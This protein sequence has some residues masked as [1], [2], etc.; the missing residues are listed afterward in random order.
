M[1]NGAEKHPCVQ[2][3][4]QARRGMARCRRCQ[5]PRPSAVSSK[6]PKQCR[7]CKTLVG[8][9]RTVC[10]SCES[11]SRV[12]VGAVKQTANETT[13]GRCRRCGGLARGSSPWCRTCRPESGAAVVTRLVRPP[14]PACPYCSNPVSLK[15]RSALT[16]SGALAHLL[17]AKSADRTIPPSRA[18]EVMAD[19]R[20]THVSKPAALA[21]PVAPAP[22]QKQK[23]ISRAELLRRIEKLRER[24]AKKKSQEAKGRPTPRPKTT[25]PTRRAATPAIKPQPY[26]GVDMKPIN[27]R[28][29]QMH[30]ESE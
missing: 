19:R 20:R 1:N 5:D 3:G 13:H 26:Y 21:S 10:S 18:R 12:D 16:P 28:W 14:A 9:S 15:K 8:P 23:Q 4:K 25:I 30:P 11:R 17:C 29:V 2:C 7:T 6:R 27:G 22:K 24:D